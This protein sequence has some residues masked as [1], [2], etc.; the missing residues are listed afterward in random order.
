SGN[1]LTA[2]LPIDFLSF[3]PPPPNAQG[4]LLDEDQWSFNLWPRSTIRVDGTPLGFGDAQI[5][6]FAPDATTFLAQAIPEPS[7]VLLLAA[8]LLGPAA[9]RLRGRLRPRRGADAAPRARAGRTPA[10]P[11]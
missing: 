10:G 4:P 9:C 11:A 6:D 3:E 8:G 5:A 7:S 2:T 1:T